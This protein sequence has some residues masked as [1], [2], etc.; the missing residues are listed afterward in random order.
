[1]K[2]ASLAFAR[3]I[4]SGCNDMTLS[5][6]FAAISMPSPDRVCCI[7]RT[8]AFILSSVAPVSLL[9]PHCSIQL[10]PLAEGCQP[11]AKESSLLCSLRCS[12]DDAINI[13]GNAQPT[14]R[15]CTLQGRKCGVRAFGSA[16]GLCEGCTIEDCGEPGIQAMDVA[17]VCLNRWVARRQTVWEAAESKRPSGLK[18]LGLLSLAIAAP[19]VRLYS[20]A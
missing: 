2:G 12:G 6:R 14:I 15:G 5:D 9:C 3:E 7:I 18:S 13:N 20:G 10:A 8:H 17:S 19:A 1:M 4:P 16:G 11:A